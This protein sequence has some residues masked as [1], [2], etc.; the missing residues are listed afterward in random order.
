M[1][2]DLTTAIFALTAEKDLPREVVIGAVEDALAVTY[3]KQYGTVP[4]VRVSMD[5]ET[6]QFHVMA[7]KKVVI[8][9]RDERTEV[10]LKVAQELDDPGGLGDLVEVDIT[11]SD[12][13][14]V[15]A[16]SAKQAILQ[17]IHEAE[18]DIVYQEF[19]H[20]EGELM[21]GVIQRVDSKGV[22][23][24]LGRAEGI[25]PPNEQVSTERYRIGQRVKVYTVEVS[26]GVRAP[27]IVLSRTHKN[28]VKRLF[29][30]EV[31]EIFSGVVEIQS[32]AREPGSRSKI[33]VMA[34]QEGVDPVGACVGIRGAR[35][36]TV[37]NELNN[38][39]VDVILYDD[40]PA[41]FVANALSPAE[42][43]GVTIDAANKRAEVVV[44]DGMLSLAIGKE[45]QNARLAAK[46]TGWRV[47]IKGAQAMQNEIEGKT[48]SA[49]ADL[50][51]V[52]E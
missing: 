51:E 15:A 43:I 2:S 31:P 35:I 22:V 34:R 17:R 42:V 52:S 46:L 10:T 8:D 45:G 44:P 29:E 21:S 28:L 26:K 4:E 33:A 38:E 49:V 37:V 7:K 47:D 48:E 3:R 14:R 18:R 1:S 30:V 36:Q 11:P 24:D 50:A 19:A 5:V 6:G 27:G 12:F 9:I 32:I 25:L 20:K 16:Q 41:R 40:D 13:S 23:L 39:K